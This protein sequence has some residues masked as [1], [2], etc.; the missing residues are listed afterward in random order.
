MV[1][2][3]QIT[4]KKMPNKR[5]IVSLTPEEHQMLKKLVNRGKTSARKINH[6]RILLLA[7]INKVGGGS[8]DEQISFAIAF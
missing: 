1:S 4:P 7:N 3:N 5:Y 6:G 8:T 2:G